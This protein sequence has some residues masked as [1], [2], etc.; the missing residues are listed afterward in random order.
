MVPGALTSCAPG[1]YVQGR[2]GKGAQVELQVSTVGAVGSS[3]LMGAKG[4]RVMDWPGL[5]Q[6]GARQPPVI[7]VL[8]KAPGALRGH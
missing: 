8:W 3:E 4:E 7:R 5:L 1:L 2:P 6:Q